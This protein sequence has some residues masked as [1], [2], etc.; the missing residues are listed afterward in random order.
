VSQCAKVCGG[1]MQCVTLLT[2]DDFDV[3]CS[4]LQCVAVCCSVLQCIAVFG[5][6]LPYVAVCYFAHLRW[7]R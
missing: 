4:V 5:S 2:R 3:C 6:G 7:V 1:V